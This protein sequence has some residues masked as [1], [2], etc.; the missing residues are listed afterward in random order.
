[1]RIINTASNASEVTA[2]LNW[3]DLQMLEDYDPIVS[4]RN[5]KLANVL[6]A[7]AL[8]KRLGGS[9]IIA[10]SVHP[11]TVM[12]NFASHAGERVQAHLKKFQKQSVVEGADTLIWLASADAPGL[13]NGG[14]FYQ[15]KPRP[16]N[17]FAEDDA[18]VERLW[19]ASE[20]LLTEAGYQI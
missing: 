14:Y 19:T 3:D 8:A 10:L 11:G 20:R 12:T 15:R 7:R 6:F 17:P 2:G 9:G 16:M 1:V 18:N 4:Y 13:S 5:S